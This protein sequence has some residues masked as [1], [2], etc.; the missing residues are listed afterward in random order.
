M[1]WY[2]EKRQLNEVIKDADDGLVMAL[3]VLPS[4]RNGADVGGRR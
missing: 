1:V 4:K 3:L 2:L